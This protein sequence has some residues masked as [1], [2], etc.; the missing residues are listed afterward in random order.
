MF[1]YFFYKYDGDKLIPILNELQ[2]G[3]IQGSLGTRV[4]WLEST[5]QKTNPLTIKMVYY[6]QFAIKDDEH[7]AYGPMIINDSTTVQYLWDEHA[8]TLQGQY[9]KS[10][11]SKA[12]ILSYYL[13]H[14]DFLF[15]NSYYS[16]LK[17]A[18]RDKAKSKLILEYLNKVKNIY[19]GQQ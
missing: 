7:G 12:Q 9:A 1:N 18:L 4:L 11:I 8:K 10:K 17:A 19:C 13:E 5:I 14:N 2:N 6:S 15:M 3:N 16:T